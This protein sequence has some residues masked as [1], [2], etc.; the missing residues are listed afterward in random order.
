LSAELRSFSIAVQPNDTI[1]NAQITVKAEDKVGNQGQG[2]SGFFA[3]APPPDTQPPQVSVVTLSKTKVKRKKDPTLQVSWTSVDNRS[4]VNHSI[5]LVPTGQSAPVELAT[6]LAGNIQAFS[7][8]IPSGVA[9]TKQAVIQ[10]VATDA[11]GNQG[12]G[13]SNQFV[14]K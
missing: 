1:S 3:I 2:V 12:Q 6:G 14:I 4:V 13:Q 9:K 11:G 10:V 7:V 5:N 8:T